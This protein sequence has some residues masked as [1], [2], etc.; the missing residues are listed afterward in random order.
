[1]TS[2]S[3]TM[4]TYRFVYLHFKFL[5]SYITPI[6]TVWFSRELSVSQGPFSG[7]L[8]FNIIQMQNAFKG[9]KFCHMIIIQE[10]LLLALCLEEEKVSK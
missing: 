4:H 1:M 2:V 3:V 9:T 7:P 10:G 6:L 8:G 5:T